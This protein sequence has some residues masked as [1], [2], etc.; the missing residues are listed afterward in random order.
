M[1]KEKEC[2]GGPQVINSAPVCWLAVLLL[3]VSGLGPTSVCE[4]S[5]VSSQ[6]EHEQQVEDGPREVRFSR[7][8]HHTEWVSRRQGTLQQLPALGWV[9]LY[10]CH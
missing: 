7:L 5:P 3:R 8:N 1:R 10:T 9:S 6:P 4:E 2:E